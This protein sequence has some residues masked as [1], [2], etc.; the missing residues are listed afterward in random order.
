[1]TNINGFIG[2]WLS[3][4]KVLHQMLEELTT[5]QLS[6]KPWEKGM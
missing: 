6:M 4:R 1:M 3:R 2:E 5:E